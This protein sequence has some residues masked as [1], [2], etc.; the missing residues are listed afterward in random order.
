M[1]GREARGSARFCRINA[2][3]DRDEFD[4]TVNKR[5]EKLLEERDALEQNK[6]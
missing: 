4:V 2:R 5:V 1:S 6:A 3:E